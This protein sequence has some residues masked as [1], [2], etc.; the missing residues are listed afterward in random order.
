[1]LTADAARPTAAGLGGAAAT[2]VWTLLGALTSVGDKLGDAGIAGV[3]GS[4]AVLLAGLLYF[5][6]PGDRG[7]K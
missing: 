1:M 3:T 7:P 2:L 4:S 6:I 5:V